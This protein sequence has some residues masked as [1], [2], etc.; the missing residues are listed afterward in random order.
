MDRHT[1]P[2]PSC[3]CILPVSDKLLISVYDAKTG[4]GKLL[5]TSSMSSIGRM[6]RETKDILRITVGEP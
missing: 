4:E 5:I 3:G 6:I 1:P 2:S